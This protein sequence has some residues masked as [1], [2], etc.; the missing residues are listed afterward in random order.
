MRFLESSFAFCSPADVERVNLFSVR[1][2]NFV[3]LIVPY[4]TAAQKY[5]R[6]TFYTYYYLMC[7][8]DAV[9]VKFKEGILKDL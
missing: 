4:V 8:R 2:S 9:A 5:V 7:L 6:K 1:F 3:R